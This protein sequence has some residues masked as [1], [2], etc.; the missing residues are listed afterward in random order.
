M[1]FITIGQISFILHK[2]AH[3][4]SAKIE[5]RRAKIQII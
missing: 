2:G 3:H 4:K 1:S 5:T